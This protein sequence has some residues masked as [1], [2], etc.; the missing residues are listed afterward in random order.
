MY[1]ET[2]FWSNHFR[3]LI[4][5]VLSSKFLFLR[6]DDE[7]AM[8]KDNGK[9]IYFQVYLNGGTFDKQRKM[10]RYRFMCLLTNCV[11]LTVISDACFLSDFFA[12]E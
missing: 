7:T 2:N 5:L 11:L 8:S 4:I 6:T 10:C 3:Y 9:V 1:G 12:T